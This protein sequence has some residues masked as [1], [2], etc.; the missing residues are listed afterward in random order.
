M[1]IFDILIVSRALGRWLAE[2]EQTAT[3]AVLC[4]IHRAEIVDFADEYDVPSGEITR[5]LGV[6]TPK[7]SPIPGA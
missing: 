6:N 7:L 4:C 1:S 2:Q 5:F 3:A